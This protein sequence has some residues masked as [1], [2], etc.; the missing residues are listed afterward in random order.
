M[1][2]DEVVDYII[3]GIPVASSRDQAHIGRFTSKA[4]LL[5]AFEKVTLR[6]RVPANDARKKEQKQ[7]DGAQRQREGGAEKKNT[8][9]SE[10][11]KR[12]FNCG[13]RNH[14]SVNCPTKTEGPK[15]FQCGERGH[16]ASKCE[17]KGKA[18]RSIRTDTRAVLRSILKM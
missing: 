15:C 10:T 4:S 14:V 9:K 18:V 13:L 5:Q 3:D 7:S 1:S 12:C 16:I 8:S 2:K 6:D 17:K 11:E